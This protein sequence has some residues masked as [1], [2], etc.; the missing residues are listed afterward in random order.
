MPTSD[1]TAITTDHPI[2]LG[3]TIGA[4]AVVILISSIII[5]VSIVC[6]WK[7]KQ[8]YI[9]HNTKNLKDSKPSSA[10]DEKVEMNQF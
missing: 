10:S 2:I 7:R 5:F 4:I 9:V 1:T 8:N 6:V 3:A